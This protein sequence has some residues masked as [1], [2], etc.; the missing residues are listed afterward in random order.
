MTSARRTAK[1]LV[2]V[3]AMM[4]V[5]G[6][7]P[8]YVFAAVGWSNAVGLAM[9]GGMGVSMGSMMG[10]GWQTGLIITGPLALLTALTVWSAPVALLAGL[11]LAVAAFL[12]GYAARVGLHNALLTSVIALGFF[13]AQPPASDTSLPAPL[14]AGLVVLITGAWVTLVVY[15]ARTWLQAPPLTGLND[16]RVVAY[17]TVLAVMVGVATWCVVHFD[18]GHSG[19]WIILTI[20][21]VFQPSL[22]A[23]FKK[24]G[25]RALGTLVGFGIALAVGAMVPSGPWLYAIG[26]LFLI[27]ALTVV[28]A[29]MHYW[30]F[31]AL[32]T[33]SIVLLES[34]GTTVTH[35][36]VDRL[37]ATTVAIIGV[38]L[39]MLAL[40]PFAHHFDVKARAR[41]GSAEPTH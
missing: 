18:L 19:A 22:G 35:V 8:A 24:A 26:T 21:V 7:L 15:L 4:V 32:L 5:T 6:F 13:V 10:R 40:S 1:T 14:F 41:A 3:V 17:S 31:A 27:L 29:Q 30:I 38:L 16:I 33:P 28:I 37:E 34:A 2:F 23:G 36:A 39:V 20:L 25:E 11:V 12:R 9:L